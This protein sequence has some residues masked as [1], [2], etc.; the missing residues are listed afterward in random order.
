MNYKYIAIEG[1]D[2]TGK[3]TLAKALAEVLDAEF[4]YEPYGGTDV[5]KALR[6]FALQKQYYD[7]VVAEA[8]EYLML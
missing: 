6:Q 1:C 4:M 3:S 8:R 2:G 5:T 7:E